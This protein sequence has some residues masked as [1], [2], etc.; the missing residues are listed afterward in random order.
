MGDDVA[1]EL[2]KV[3][4]GSGGKQE[5]SWERIHASLHRIMTPLMNEGFFAEVVVLV[6][7]EEDRAAILGV[8][9]AFGIDLEGNGVS[10]ISCGGKATIFAPL[11]IFRQFGIRT[12]VVWDGDHGNASE[13]SKNRQL[14]QLL[15]ATPEDFPDTNIGPEYACFKGKIA[16]ILRE[17]LGGTFF[18]DTM[19]DCIDDL[20]IRG[21]A[22]PDK[23]P[24]ALTQCIKEAYRQ[25]RRC[26]TL[27]Q[28][29]QQIMVKKLFTLNPHPTRIRAAH[30]GTSGS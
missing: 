9:Y 7:G 30:A 27:E 10:V 4:P 19:S 22:N 29:V 21:K 28:V 17:D 16:D 8:A 18:D 15:G 14:L 6:E 3:K 25:G 2:G 13:K 24:I 20:G 5:H 12:Y 11:V 26:K 23:N 1:E